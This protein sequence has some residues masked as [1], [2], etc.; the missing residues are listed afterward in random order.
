VPQELARQSD[1]ASLVGREVATL[2]DLHAQRREVVGRHALNVDAGAI[3]GI[4]VGCMALMM[5]S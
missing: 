2:D 4:G 5:F 3:G 1:D